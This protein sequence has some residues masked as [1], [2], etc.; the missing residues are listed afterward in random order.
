M[1]GLAFF[2]AKKRGEEDEEEETSSFQASSSCS[3]VSVSVSPEEIRTVGCHGRWL[4]GAADLFFHLPLS[5]LLEVYFPVGF[6]VDNSLKESDNVPF[7][8]SC[9]VY[10]VTTESV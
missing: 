3:H 6:K 5:V 10:M 7:G 4:V 2:H 9:V 8:R 1:A